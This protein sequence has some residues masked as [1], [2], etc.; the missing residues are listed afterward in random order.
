MTQFD[1]HYQLDKKRFHKYADHNAL[2]NQ[3]ILCGK[4]MVKIVYFMLCCMFLTACCTSYREA[5][6]L[7]TF[8][9]I[10]GDT[11]VVKDYSVSYHGNGKN[12]DVFYRELLL[13]IIRFIKHIKN[14]FAMCR[15]LKWSVGVRMHFPWMILLFLYI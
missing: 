11:T 1:L 4:C 7:S 2:C 8:A 12:M 3:K 9:G 14:T 6:Q 13:M 5:S 15:V 10:L